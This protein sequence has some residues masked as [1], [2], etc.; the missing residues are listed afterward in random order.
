LALT[1]GIIGL[2]LGVLIGIPVAL[3]FGLISLFS[4]SG[5]GKD[6]KYKIN[7]LYG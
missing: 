5:G 1:A 3:I 4:L 2:V 6:N 7:M